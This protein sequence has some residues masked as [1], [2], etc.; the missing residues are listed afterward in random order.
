M[1]RKGFR[2]VSLGISIRWALIT[3]K[4]LSSVCG[5]L[6][7]ATCLTWPASDRTQYRELARNTERN[8]GWSEKIASRTIGLAESVVRE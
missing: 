4:S 6:T 1:D 3:T 7:R 8:E 5:T 2:I